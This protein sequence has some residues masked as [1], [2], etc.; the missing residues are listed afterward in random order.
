MLPNIVHSYR[1]P[2]DIFDDGIDRNM[3][4]GI[5]GIFFFSVFTWMWKDSNRIMH[6]FILVLV[7]GIILNLVEFIIFCW[8]KNSMK[9]ISIS[10]YVSLD[11]TLTRVFV[12][13]WI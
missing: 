8:A 9:R 3:T 2:I 13:T 5:I 7:Y 10:T 6:G 1:L 4:G 11:H 12:C